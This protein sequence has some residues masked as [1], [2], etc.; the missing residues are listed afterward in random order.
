VCLSLCLSLSLFSSLPPSL[1]S[2]F[3]THLWAQSLSQPLITG[4]S[5]LLQ[6]PPPKWCHCSF[7]ATLPVASY[8]CVFHSDFSTEIE[9][10]INMLPPFG[11]V[12][13]FQD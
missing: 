13:G 10:H 12:S 7:K 1:P 9:A 8:T 5:V 3:Q 4:G 2:M 11:Y 6:T